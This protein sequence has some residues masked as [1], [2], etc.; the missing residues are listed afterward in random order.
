[1]MIEN[2]SK[3]IAPEILKIYIDNDISL[4]LE[5]NPFA[6]PGEELGVNQMDNANNNPFSKDQIS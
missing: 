2:K 4:A 3:Y 5:S 1:M 6:G